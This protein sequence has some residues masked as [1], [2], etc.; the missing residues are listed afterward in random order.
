MSEKR[1][2]LSGSKL[3]LTEN[4]GEAYRVESGRVLVFIIPLKDEK[5]GRRWLLAEVE[6]GDTVP[7]L[8]HES[9]DAKGEPRKWTFGLSALEPGELT[10][11][12]GSNEYEDAFAQ[13]AGLKK[14][15][16]LGFAESV[17]ESY[18]LESMREQRNLFATGEERKNTYRRTLT[19]IY[20]LFSSTKSERRQMHEPTG[21]RL[22]D[23]CV[24]LCDIQGIDPAGLSVIQSSCGRRFGPKDVA[25]ISGFICRDILL[26]E[27]WYKKDSGPLLVFRSGSK[28]PAVCMHQKAGKYMLWDPADDSTVAITEE[29]AAMIDPRAMV[30]YR[31]FPREKITLKKL[32]L[33]A[34]QDLNW[35]DVTALLLL[36]LLGT[37]IG[38]LLPYLNEQMYD[39]FIPL[40]DIPGLYGVCAVVLACAMGNICFTIVKNLANFRAINRMKYSVQAAVMHRLFNLPESFF[41]DYDSADLGQ[42]AMGISSMFT[43]LA[44]TAVGVVLSAVFSM[45]YLW[46]M[47]SYSSQ[48]SL[49]SILM[50]AVVM[51]I[52]V[53]LGRQEMKYER[54]QMEIDGKI[55]SMMF[56]FLSGIS[57]LR[58]AGAEN[59][60]LYEYLRRYT[61]SRKLDLRKERFSLVVG[62][63]GN[64]ASTVFSVVFYYMMIH[65]SI[66]LSM[67]AFMGFSTAF[68]SFSGALMS[69]VSAYL[70]VNAIGPA[71]ERMKPILETLPEQEE[72]A[73]IP[74]EISGEIEV[75]NL[76][77]AYSEDT[78]PVLNGI[79]FHIKPGEYIGIVGS[80]GCGKSTLLKLLLGFEKPQSGRIYYDGRD[81]DT[82]DKRELRKKFG[83]VLQN[84]GIITGSIQENITI[85][86]PS[87]TLEAVKQAVKDAGLEKDIAEM[88]MGLHTVLSE[89]DGSISGGQQQ[90]ILI[91]RAIVGKPKLLFFDEATS[92]LDNVTQAAV[93][94]SLDKLNSTR[95]VIAHRLSTIIH[96]DRIFVMDAG[97]IVEE[98]N[99]DEL[100]EKKGI[101]YNLASRQ[102]S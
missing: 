68:G 66:E 58:I 69:L 34:L 75:S 26:E 77:F 85:T 47:F 81:I 1:I 36:T 90:R 51:V 82:L 56:Q 97:R 89:G 37:L 79:S 12:E 74:G 14:Y 52:V 43:M 44:S 64:C 32:M 98:G 86:T 33:F 41:R 78:P 91:A 54:E 21:N 10:V 71:F 28:A 73:G 48:M 20:K 80:S 5:K 70:R 50:L 57:K 101:F 29:T 46:R 62:M 59:R 22:Y 39:L 7:A 60:A 76:E 63:L 8:I 11:V 87:A 53:I 102:I 23:A 55:G 40:G 18:R 92:A 83:V 4:A 88:P 99:F 35:R 24:R 27:K 94:E 61:E 31:P 38:L 15:K 93:C 6:P 65:Q 19:V 96:C 67:G 25:R 84:G 16:Q 17:V 72:D 30:F 49:I 3:F 42:R 2:A 9:D 13:K 45:L 95:V 100:M